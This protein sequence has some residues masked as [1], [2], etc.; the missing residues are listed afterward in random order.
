V[1]VGIDGLSP[2]GLRQ[3]RTPVVDSLMAGGAFTF[4]ARGVFPTSSSPNWASM[5][6]GAG[7]EQHGIT[8][9]DWEPNKFDIAPVIK[10]KDGRF[11]TVFGLLR[12][13][14]PNA[15]SACFYDWGGF[16]RLVEP[17]AADRLADTDGPT[18]AVREAMA[19]FRQTRPVLMF[20]QLDHVD[21]AGHQHGHGSAEYYA[22]VEAADR[23]IGE[24]IDGL[25]TA[26]AWSRTVLLVTSDHG[27]KA[28]GHGGATMDELQIPWIIHGPGIARGREIQSPVYTYDTAAT[29][30]TL[31]GLRPPAAWIGRPVREAF[32]KGLG[33]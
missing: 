25:K 14:Q 4:Q 23:L 13:Q 19:Y 6:M 18:N 24:L 11:P 33:Q 2:D 31:L 30:A 29:V 15:A 32:L 28:K 5:I 3:A 9:N 1:I 22:A 17:L 21:H 27:G 26:G 10:G 16:G 8:S 20:I 12:E 7:P